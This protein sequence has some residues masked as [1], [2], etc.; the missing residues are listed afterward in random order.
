MLRKTAIATF[1]FSGTVALTNLPA[2]ALTLGTYNFDTNTGAPSGVDSNLTFS[3]FTA[4]GLTA[5]TGGAVP[6][7]STGVAGSAIN[8]SNWATGAIDPNSKYYSF[9]VTPSSGTQISLNSLVFAAQRSTQGPQTIE[10]RSSVDN[11][12]ASLTFTAPIPPG[13]AAIANP[14]FTSYT[15]SLAS[16]SL[17]NLTSDVTF[18]IY[19]YNTGAT[20]G[21]LRL[22]NVVLDGTM[23]PVAVPFG[24]TPIWGL[25]A[26][27]VVF[28]L[29]KLRKR[30]KSNSDGVEAEINL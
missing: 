24:F 2:H 1:L 12:A 26:N 3:N 15:V 19:G 13:T 28:G 21:T 27:G 11:Y 20:G 29:R 6:G 8:Y 4:T 10:I 7:F 9:T 17:Q 14:S 30:T 5:V 18:R 23:Q 16:P 22:D 25:A